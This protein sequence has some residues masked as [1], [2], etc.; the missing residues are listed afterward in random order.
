MVAR[1]LSFGRFIGVVSLVF[2]L[3][4]AASIALP[5][6]PYIRFQN[7]KGTIYDRMGWIYE[8][9]HYDDAPI[10]VAFLGSSRTG[11]GIYPTLLEPAL[12]ARGV[13]ARV[14]NFALPATGFDI[15]ETIALE[16]LSTRPVKLI[17]FDVG[18]AF[19]RDGH[20]AFG[21]VASLRE[22]ETAPWL[23]NRTLPRN[24]VRL[25]LRQISLAFNS[26]APDVFGFRR[27]F[28]AAR[29]PGST[30]DPRSMLNLPEDFDKLGTAEHKA[31]LEAQSRLRHQQLRP[32]FLP[33][34]FADIEFGV[35]R[36]YVERVAALAA[37][38][39]AKVVF[40]YLPFYKGPLAPREE[41]W[42]KGFGPI[43]KANF[44]VDDPNF[45]ED[46][47]HTAATPQVKNAL[48]NW[49]ADQVA[50]LLK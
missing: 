28:D 2:A 19:P 12:A 13:S 49:V 45:F 17:V 38:R 42:L 40:L 30:I 47:A 22:L 5:H 35:S 36:T 48:T 1:S 24:L 23:V 43:L 46:S 3:C 50:P 14:V 31:K 15:R 18:E 11:A 6:S 21:D 9:I 34:R 4:A 29:Y 16:L 25:P 37:S 26:V 10:D 20:E 44:M 41:A 39:N 32:P 33:G 27:S 8:R 7:L